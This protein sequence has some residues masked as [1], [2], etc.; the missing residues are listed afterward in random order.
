MASFVSEGI[1]QQCI[2]KMEILPPES[3]HCFRRDGDCY[4][5]SVYSGRIAALLIGYKKGRLPTAHSVL[6]T[7]F[8]AHLQYYAN[9][10]IEGNGNIILTYPPGSIKSRLYRGYDHMNRLCVSLHKKLLLPPQIT[11]RAGATV[12]SKAN[13]QSRMTPPSAG[14]KAEIRMLFK[15]NPS[16][17]Q[18]TLNRETRQENM[19]HAVSLRRNRLSGMTPACN[20]IIVDDVITTGATLG[21]CRELL[22]QAGFTR[23]HCIALFTD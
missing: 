22:I 8:I 12:A 10:C 16:A 13:E 9:E 3:K 21:K 20:I 2:E 19:K 6:A 1:C 4:V 15:R 5:C 7:I 18:K 17:S 23:V 11:K 14:L